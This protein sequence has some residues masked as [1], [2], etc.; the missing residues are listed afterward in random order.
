MPERAAP[1][2]VATEVPYGIDRRP[3]PQGTALEA[4]VPPSVGAFRRPPLPTGATPPTEEDLTVSYNAGQDSVDFGFSLPESA[5]DAQ[6]AV[7][8]TREDAVA[9]KVDLRRSQYSVGKDPSYFK[10]ERFMAWSRGRYFF[11]AHASSPAA[12]DRFMQAFPY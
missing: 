7:T 9:S 1:H 6:A 11:Y 10:T 3:M 2:V 12:L 4:L 8:T 5:A